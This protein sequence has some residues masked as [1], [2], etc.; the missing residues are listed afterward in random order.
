MKTKQIL[1]ATLLL[2]SSL[3]GSSYTVDSSHSSVAFKV[4]HMMISNVKG[5][6]DTFKGEFEYDE[7]T[8]TLQSLKGNVEVAS[9]NTANKDRDKHLK[10]SD[11]FDVNKYPKIVFELTSVK[12]EK[13]YGNLTMKGVSKKIELDYEA[14]GTIVN[15]WGKHVAGFS[16]YGKIKRSD[17]GI[18]WNKV[19]EAGGV[20]VSDIVK[21]EIE[22]EGF[23]Q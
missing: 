6:F 21:L 9:I 10:A 17:F 19:L 4:K 7:K 3:F 16:L 15:P 13:A 14:G 12:G 1:L 18:T 11:V 20:A 2:T 22:V 5:S 8:N 23:K